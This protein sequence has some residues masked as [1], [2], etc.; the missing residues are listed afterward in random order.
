MLQ[1]GL[2]QSESSDANEPAF[3]PANKPYDALGGGAAV[4]RLVDAFYD[5]MDSEP[6]FAGIRLLH[7]NDLSGSR[8]KLF[9]FLSGWLGGP[10]LYIQKYGHP[11]LRGRHMPF[12]I[13]EVQR[14]QWLACMQKTMDEL[15]ITGDI[16][17]FLDARFR[18]VADFMRNQ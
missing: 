4:K 14:D 1:P 3:G 6:A 10:P 9:E 7:P 18:H 8:E 12:A 15:N 16:R 5:N 17:M 13:G 11:R 2:P